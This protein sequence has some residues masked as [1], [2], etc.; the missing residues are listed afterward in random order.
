[1]KRLVCVLVSSCWAVVA[2]GAEVPEDS[3][4][5][6]KADLSGPV[7]EADAVRLSRD[8]LAAST[9]EKPALELAIRRYRGPVEPVIRKLIASE[10]RC[11][12]PET[13]FIEAQHFTAPGLKDRYREDLLYFFVPKAYETTKP[14]GLLIFMHGGGPGSP[15]EAAKVVLSDPKTHKSSYGLRPFIED[16]PFIAVAP[17]AP[18]N[19]KS[20]AR[21]CLPEADDYIAAVIRECRHRFNIDRD[22]VFLGGQSMGGFGA[23]HLCQRLPDRIAGG[24]ACGGSWSA[25]NWRC[26]VG[27]PL[28]II[29][30]AKDAIAP[31]TPGKKARPRFTDVFFARAAHDLLTQAGVD[32][33]YA[34][35]ER[36]HPLGE[37]QGPLSK[38]VPWMKSLRR[39]PLSPRVVA[40]TP[41]G[42][43]AQT[44]SPAPHCRWISILDIGDDKIPFD[45]VKR[46]GP[47]PHWGETLEEFS[48]QGFELV[49]LTVRG[50]IVDAR[51][52]SHNAFDVTT[53]NVRRF[54]IWL[55]PAMV[56]FS[57]PIVV[58]V[59]GRKQSYRAKPNLPDTLRSYQ[60]RND[61]GLI[62]HCELV[63]STDG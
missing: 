8:F 55:H 58:T 11:W 61:W 7:S 42:W 45:A 14:F 43:N 23:Y 27:T 21:W 12:K 53:T 47:G 60:R 10:E 32:H 15:R 18:W 36:G 48:R 9:D 62:Y 54:S 25:S 51:Y 37:A 44:D 46:T 2:C 33:V 24:I 5:R 26:M 13:G 22:R 28:F 19:E 39:D 17:S 30:G 41:R 35:H 1:M 20:S 63:I 59:N 3:Q 52:L 49:E 40:V 50:G 16:A 56:D 6:G 38:F 57:K 29:H 34:E 4:I 31:G